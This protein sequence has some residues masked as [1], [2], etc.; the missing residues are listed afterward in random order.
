MLADIAEEKKEEA[1]K[2]RRQEET[3][4]AEEPV[5]RLKLKA[6]LAR[7]ALRDGERLTRK[8]EAGTVRFAWLSEKEQQLVQDYDSRRLHVRVDQANEKYGHGIAR[9]NDFGCR[10]GENMCRD[11][12]IEVRAHLRTLQRS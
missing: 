11:V 3:H 4:G 10:A 2:R 12:P 6:H 8:V 5:W 9:T 7:K 1:D